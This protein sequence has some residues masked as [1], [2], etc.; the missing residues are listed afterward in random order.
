VIERAQL[1]K[2]LHHVEDDVRLLL[3]D[4]AA[5]DREVVAHAEWMYFVSHLPQRRQHVVLGLPLDGQQIVSGHVIRRHHV[6]VHE[7]EHAQHSHSATRWR[8][9][10]R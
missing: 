3:L 4:G 8:P 7:H 9:L 5:D 10:C 2:R 1:V 6:V